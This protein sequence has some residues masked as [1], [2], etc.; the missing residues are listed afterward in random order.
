LAQDNEQLAE[1]MGGGVHSHALSGDEHVHCG[2]T[3][4]ELLVAWAG[5]LAYKS[6]SPLVVPGVELVRI[7]MDGPQSSVR[8]RRTRTGVEAIG[9]GRIVADFMGDGV[10]QEVQQFAPPSASHEG[11]ATIG[12]FSQHN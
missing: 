7:H 5:H 2:Q 1:F 12:R 10:F 3:D 9:T 8:I 11:V 4:A 6:G